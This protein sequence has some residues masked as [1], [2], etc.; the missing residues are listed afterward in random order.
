MYPKSPNYGTSEE[1][2]QTQISFPPQHQ[3]RQ[4]GL[5]YLMDPRPISENPDSLYVSGQVLHVN[6]G[7]I[8]GS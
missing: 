2:N 5:E 4:P 7:T 3:E 8:T 6:G 1:C